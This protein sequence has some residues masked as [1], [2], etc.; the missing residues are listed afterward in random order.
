FDLARSVDLHLRSAAW[1]GEQAVGGGTKDLLDLGDLVT[2]RGRHFGIWW[3]LTS[4]ITAFDRP[5]FFRDVQVQ[6]PF[7]RM[8]HDHTFEEVGEGTRMIDRFLFEAPCGA[9]G[10]WVSRAVLARHLQR[11]LEKRAAFL[12]EIA[13]AS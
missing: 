7:A 10:R 3:K 6:G 12:R 1:T 9:L 11:F 8:E 4:R 5:S 13:E 2:F